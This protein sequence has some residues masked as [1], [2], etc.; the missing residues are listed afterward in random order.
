MKFASILASVFCLVS[1]SF[2]QTQLS[3]FYGVNELS[4]TGTVRAVA[5][6]GNT[7]FIGGTFTE[8]N[9]PC[10]NAAF[11]DATTGDADRFFPKFDDRVFAI[12]SD[13]NNGWY[14]GGMFTHTHGHPIKYL[15]HINA[16]HSVDTSF[17]LSLNSFV[18]CITVSDSTLYFGGVFTSVLGITRNHIAAV[19]INSRQV[20]SWD[21]NADQS[22]TAIAVV[23][24]LVYAGGY[25]NGIGGQVRLVVASLSRSTGLA[26]NAFQ[27]GTGGPSGNSYI[28]SFMQA[29]GKLYMA[30]SFSIINSVSRYC[31]V[32]VDPVTGNVDSSW[33]PGN[34]FSGFA[35][36]SAIIVGNVMYVGGGFTNIGGA[37]RNNLVAIDLATG[38]ATS[39]NPNIDNTVTSIAMSG[40]KLV[41]GG[42]FTKIGV[43]SQSYLAMVDTSTGVATNWNPNLD[44]RVYAIYTNGNTVIVG[45]LFN[46][47]NRVPRT[48]LAAIDAVTGKVKSGWIA[49][50]GSTVNALAVSNGK[51]LAGGSFTNIGAS[52]VSY[53]AALDT[54]T[55]A[56]IPFFPSAGSTIYSIYPYGT[57]IYVG[58]GFTSFTGGS[59][60]GLA[61][62]DASS[63]KLLSWNPTMDYGGGLAFA[64]LGGTIYVAGF[65]NTINGAARNYLAAFDTTSDQLLPWN[66]NANQMTQALTAANGL[67]Y[68]G[69]DFTTVGGLTHKKLAAVDAVT[70]VPNG[71]NVSADYTVYTLATAGTS[72]YAGGIFTTINGLPKQNVAIIDLLANAP[73][74]WSP[75]DVG[76]YVYSIALAEQRVYIGGFFLSMSYITSNSVGVL[77]I[78]T[79]TL[80]KPAFALFGSKSIYFGKVKIGTSKDTTVAIF[81]SGDDTLKIQSFTSIDSSF[82]VTQKQFAVLPQQTSFDSIRFTPLK[83][84]SIVSVFLVTSNSLS[85]IDTLRFSGV[86]VAAARIA[87]IHHN[88][89]TINFGVVNLNSF[90]D[91]TFIVS[92]TGNDTLH[93]TLV[94]T[95]NARFVPK[96][97]SF[98][99]APNGSFTDSLRFTADSVGTFKAL[100]LITSDATNKVTDTIIVIGVCQKVTSVA[101]GSTIPGTF[102]LSQNYPNPFNPSTVISYQSPVN[103]H[104]TLKLYDVIGREVA[105]LVDEVKEAGSYEVKVDASRLSSGVYFYRMQAGN[106]VEMKKMVLMK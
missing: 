28:Q 42:Y 32:A 78:P 15:A 94:V 65:F 4:S 48:N 7:L 79:L 99:L 101:S 2:S 86:G 90:K 41:V 21:P 26:T 43:K 20:T 76:Q 5:A 69:G 87:D 44:E 16:D 56:T 97:T 85:S 84:D 36:S 98:L 72:L 33:N 83:A 13:N 3:Q 96:K 53:L 46:S 102:S 22:V 23:G 11:L 18:N 80:K 12:V 10:G 70:G 73:T 60:N 68:L 82:V 30:G 88:R 103:S 64:G 93:G 106:Y 50:A 77:S 14:V 71:F 57:R 52:S 25:F 95:T 105:T 31:L 67:V 1:L 100:V 47:V 58:G 66:P 61:A 34:G 92:T 55:G 8:V 81:N 24:N 74:S 45:G 59:R 19:N 9:F 91:T 104:I 37:A 75:N 38:T 40:N 29:N 35:V 6:A 63:G 17:N 54:A 51:L 27:S 62:F 39:W 89:D 49:N